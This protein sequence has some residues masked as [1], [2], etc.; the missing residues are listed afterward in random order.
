MLSKLV[1]LPL[2]LVDSLV[3]HTLFF[4]LCCCRAAV[5]KPQQEGSNKIHGQFYNYKRTCIN[6]QLLW[7]IGAESAG[8][9]LLS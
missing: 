9:S 8:I 6:E 1:H 7:N 5:F 4:S 2:K 3:E